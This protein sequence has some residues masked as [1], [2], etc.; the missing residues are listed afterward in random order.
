MNRDYIIV[1]EIKDRWGE[2]LAYARARDERHPYDAIVA[3]W[4]NETHGHF[5]GEPTDADEVQKALYS[6]YAYAYLWVNSTRTTAYCDGVREK[7][8][9]PPAWLFGKEP[10]R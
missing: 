3:D 1:M 5:R 4:L 9:T 2:L 7:P 6:K 8:R 10:I